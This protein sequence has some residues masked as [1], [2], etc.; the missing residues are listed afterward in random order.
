MVGLGREPKIGDSSPYAAHVDEILEHF[1]ALVEQAQELAF[2]PLRKGVAA[3]PDMTGWSRFRRIAFAVSSPFFTTFTGESAPRSGVILLAWLTVCVYWLGFADLFVD[4]IFGALPPATSQSE[5]AIW[6][7]VGAWLMLAV[8]AVLPFAAYWRWVE[9]VRDLRYPGYW[10]LILTVLFIT[11][12]CSSPYWAIDAEYCTQF[13]SHLLHDRAD[14]VLFIFTYVLFLIPAGT[15]LYMFAIDTL[16]LSA[17]L[18][19]VTGKYLRS[20]HSPFPR[21]L[22]RKLV[23]EPIPG[24]GTGREDWMLIDLEE[25]ELRLLHEWA[26]ANR[27]A[28]DKRLLPTVILFG[29]LGAFANTQT[30]GNSVDRAL[31]WLYDSFRLTSTGTSLLLWTGRYM[32]AAL[33]V[34]FA[35]MF[36]YSLLLLFRNLV[37]QSLIIEACVVAEYAREQ[38]RVAD[39]TDKTTKGR[40]GFWER[41]LR[42]LLGR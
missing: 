7:R 14:L 5:S 8:I 39:S 15:F 11:I 23:L 33:L 32:T 29:I 42:L 34:A 20:A 6:V 4:H 38:R 28:T 30:F 12:V 40:M 25:K 19:W 31:S 35:V 26:A 2:P 17:W 3:P 36:V 37:A 27:A 18:L 9:F 1:S 13:P 24:C 22:V 41:L 21:E 16:L 10:R